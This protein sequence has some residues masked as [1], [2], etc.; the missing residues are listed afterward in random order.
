LDEVRKLYELVRSLI[1]LLVE[2]S[3]LVVSIEAVHVAH[4]GGG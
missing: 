2:R 3:R 4:D 1:L